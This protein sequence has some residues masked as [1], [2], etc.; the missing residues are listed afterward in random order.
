MNRSIVGIAMV[1]VALVSGRCF[2]ADEISK[3]ALVGVDLIVSQ[4][5]PGM[6]RAEVETQLTDRDGGPQSITCTRYYQPTGLIIEVPYDQTGGTWTLT[7][8]V[9]GPL[10]IRVGTRSS[11]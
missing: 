1:G 11:L 4:I 2:A 5:H 3:V 9:N 7:N 8:R 6:T 10:N